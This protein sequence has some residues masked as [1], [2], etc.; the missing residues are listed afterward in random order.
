MTRAYG[1]IVLAV[2][3]VAAAWAFRVRLDSIDPPAVAPLTAAEALQTRLLS[4]NIRRPSDAGLRLKYED[5]NRDHFDG[6]LPPLTIRWE[7]GLAGVGNLAARKFTLEGLFGEIGSREVILL[8]PSLQT[9]P[10]ALMRALCHEMV[11]ASLFSHGNRSTNH[12][13][14]FRAE[15][16]RLSAAGAF[17]GMP[18]SDEDKAALRQWLDAESARLAA[19]K[20]AIDRMTVDPS[21]D[22]ASLNDRIA[23][24]HDDV[25]LFNRE[26][27]RYNLMIVYP[28]GFDEDS[29][30]SQ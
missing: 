19:E 7:A 10:A 1:V 26:V 13:A 20:E 8:N 24:D 16:R 5:I 21:Q 11:H 25:E 12:G 6:A 9:D 22:R 28:D 23:R 27:T 14:A 29:G 4:E 2:I 3:I 18:A 17:E 30:S 15:L